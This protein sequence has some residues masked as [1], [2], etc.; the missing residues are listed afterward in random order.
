MEVVGDVCRSVV[1]NYSVGADVGRAFV[2]QIVVGYRFNGFVFVVES[3]V[4]RY[5][6]PVFYHSE[7]DHRDGFG[8]FVLRYACVHRRLIAGIYA[9]ED[10][11]HVRRVVDFAV[12]RVGDAYRFII[13][14]ARV[15]SGVM[16]Y[17]FFPF[18][19]F[20]VDLEDGR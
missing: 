14:C 2:D 4:A 12:V 1:A 13:R 19:I 10:Y 11:G 18:R 16:D 7:V 6:I 17:D 20:V 3:I 5:P 8:A 9:N 15:R